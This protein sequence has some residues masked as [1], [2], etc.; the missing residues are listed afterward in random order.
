MAAAAYAKD[1]LGIIAPNKI[2]AERKLS[3]VLAGG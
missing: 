1:L 2:Q 3:D